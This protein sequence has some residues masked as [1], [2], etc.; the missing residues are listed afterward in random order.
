MT[1]IKHMTLKIASYIFYVKFVF[2][3]LPLN[4]NDFFYF[5]LNITRHSIL[6]EKQI[7]MISEFYLVSL[8]LP[9]LCMFAY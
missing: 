5:L 9:L 7:V 8:K 3:T 4:K 6:Q 2:F 1:Q